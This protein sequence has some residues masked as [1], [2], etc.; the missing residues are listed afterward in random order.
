MCTRGVPHKNKS[1]RYSEMDCKESLAWGSPRFQQHSLNLRVD[2][3]STADA[4][5]TTIDGI[6]AHATIEPEY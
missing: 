6:A 4:V 1:V 3:L 5:L 2:P